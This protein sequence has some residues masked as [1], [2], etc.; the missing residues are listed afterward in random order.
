MCGLQ[1]ESIQKRLLTEA[2]LNLAR[3]LSIAQ[4][5]EAA[6][7]NTQSLK[8][9]DTS[10]RHLSL[11]KHISARP[12]KGSPHGKDNAGPRNPSCYRCSL[13]NQDTADCHHRDLECHRCGEKG[14][15]APM[16]RNKAAQPSPEALPQTSKKSS[17]NQCRK[18]SLC[19]TQ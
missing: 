5:M 7:K 1:S 13:S 8:S 14:H 11:N 9:Q 16:C 15:L 2:D 3:V 6:N 10:I 18:Q 12:V 17:V 19:R 4:G